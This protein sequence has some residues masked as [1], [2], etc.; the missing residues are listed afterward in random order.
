MTDYIIQR[1]KDAARITD[2]IGAFYPLHRSGKEYTCLCPFHDDSH[3]GSFKISPSKN[4][5]KCFAC[6]AGGD[7]V[8]F[9]MRLEGLSFPDAIRWLGRMYG[10]DADDG[11]Y[12]APSNAGI[13]PQARPLPPPLPTLYLED[14]LVSTTEKSTDNALCNHLRQLPWS[15]GQSAR[16]ETTLKDYHIGT[17]CDGHIVF[18]Q[19]DEGGNARTGKLMWYGPDGHR[20]KQ[21]HGSVGWV[22][23][24]IGYDD[25][26]FE[27]RQVLFGLHLMRRYPQAEVHI[28]ESEKTALYCAIFFGQPERHIWMATGGKEN[29]TA[30]RLQPL[31]NAHRTIAIHPDRDAQEQWSQSCQQLG[32]N[33]AYVNNLMER[34]WQPADGEKADLADVLTPRGSE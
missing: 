3:L 16:L 33:R 25:K 9:L 30:A 22:H 23:S 21:R 15:P 5:Y 29:L 28:V 12:V 2:V 11:G 1:I 13:K 4:L 10:I 27:V 18:W 7:S 26:N 24:R 32:Y 8:D 20:D 34:F 19:L 6:G 31:M 17:W 14:H